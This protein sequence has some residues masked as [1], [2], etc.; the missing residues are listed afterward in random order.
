[1]LAKQIFDESYQFWKLPSGREKDLLF[2]LKVD[3]NFLFEVLLYFRS[4]RK[5]IGTW[6]WLCSMNANA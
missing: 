4:P 1:V 3:F 6:N 2:S 5:E